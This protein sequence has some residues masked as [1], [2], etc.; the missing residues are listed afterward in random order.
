[1]SGFEEEKT[2]LMKKYRKISVDEAGKFAP[3]NYVVDVV[4]VNDKNYTVQ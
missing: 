2:D 4:F 3:N 1:V